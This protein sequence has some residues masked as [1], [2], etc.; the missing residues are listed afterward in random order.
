MRILPSIDLKDGKVVRLYKGDF[1]T[2]HTVADSAEETARRFLDAGATL[3]H[4][5]DLDGAKTGGGAN[6]RLVRDVIAHTG[7]AVELGGGIRS[8]EDI[9]DVLALGVSRVV[10]GSA[11]VEKPELVPAAVEAYGEKIAVGIDAQKGTVRTRGWV[12]DSGLPYLDFARKMESC[13]VRTIIFTDIDRDGLQKGPSFAYLQALREAVGCEIVASGGVTTLEDVVR[14]RDMGIDAAIVGKA[15][16][17]GA[18]DLRRA[19]ELAGL[20]R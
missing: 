4:M 8:M 19:V 5:V 13:G 3:L 20:G 18:M 12:E 17:T 15:A 10:L 7:A 1:A 11:A 14:L 6:R 16:Y 2:T 9:A